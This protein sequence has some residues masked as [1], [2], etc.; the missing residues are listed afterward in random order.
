MSEQAELCVFCPFVW[1][2]RGCFV[3]GVSQA[4]FLVLG[5][6]E[7]ALAAHGVRA[8]QGDV[9]L[10]QHGQNLIVVPVGGQNDRS[11]VHGGGVFWIL[12]A[13]HQFLKTEERGGGGA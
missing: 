3:P 11:H 10:Q 5:V 2:Q 6:A 1:E 8:G 7:G 12:D 4:V 9:L 13:L